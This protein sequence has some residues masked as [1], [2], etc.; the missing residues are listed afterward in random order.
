[1]P[2]VLIVEASGQAKPE[3]LDVPELTEFRE[4]IGTK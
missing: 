4:A 2:H 3:V 1:L